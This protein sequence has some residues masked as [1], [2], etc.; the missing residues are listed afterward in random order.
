M[1]QWRPAYC[2]ASQE[3]VKALSLLS[4]ELYGSGFREEHVSQLLGAADAI[5]LLSDSALYSLLSI[6]AVATLHGTAPG[7]LAQLFVRNGE[8][9]KEQYM[10]ILPPKLRHLLEVLGI[11]EFYGPVVSSQV[12]ISPCSSMFFLSDPLF[13]CYESQGNRPV[14]ASVPNFVMPPHASSFLLLREVE[15][16]GGRLVDVGCGSG[17]LG[18]LLSD[19]YHSSFGMDVNPRAV[20]YSQVNSLINDRDARFRREDFRRPREDYGHVD[21]VIFNAPTRSLPIASARET[22]SLGAQQIVTGFIQSISRILAKGGLAQLLVTVQVPEGY[23]SASD[24][25]QEWVG[26]SLRVTFD[27]KVT[28]IPG[29]V[30]G[31]PSAEIEA[32]RLQPGSLLVDD[33]GGADLLMTYLV[34][35][36]I[37]EV[38]PTIVSI[39]M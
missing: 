16:I 34:A 17:A 39:V 32:G 26:S 14:M 25:V 10:Q 27:L 11:L 20:A 5:D 28:S 18:L 38:V 19:H 31:I 30:L 3:A 36:R 13:R 21:H 12:S 23:A 1:T 35:N 2:L 15:P 8:V 9:L 7:I 4:A 6:D 37:R 33:E 22:G 24:V 29:S